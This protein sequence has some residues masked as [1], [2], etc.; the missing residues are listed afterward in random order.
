MKIQILLSPASPKNLT[1][2]TR[3]NVILWGVHSSFLYFKPGIKPMPPVV[4][5]RSLNHCGLPGKFRRVPGG[6]GGNVQPSGLPLAY[7]T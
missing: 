6:A 1:E 5:A 7:Y 4:E 2:Y 3:Q